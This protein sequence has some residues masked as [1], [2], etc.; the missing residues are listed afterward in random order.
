M[1]QNDINID[2][3]KQM[4]DHEHFVAIDERDL[5]IV[6]DSNDYYPQYGFHKYIKKRLTYEEEQI[7]RGN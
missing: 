7:A 3:K 4:D 6:N 2:I 1:N 5:D